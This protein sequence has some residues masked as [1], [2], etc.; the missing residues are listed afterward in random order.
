[1]QGIVKPKGLRVARRI[2]A[3][4]PATAAASA[5]E[6][7]LCLWGLMRRLSGDDAYER[8]LRHHAAAHPGEA[9]LSRKEFFRREQERKWSGVRRC[10]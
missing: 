3:V 6:K 1:M 5:V 8:Y 4:F 2:S 7:V 9:P 10:C